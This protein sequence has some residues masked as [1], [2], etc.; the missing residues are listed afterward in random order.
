MKREVERNEKT[1]NGKKMPFFSFSFSP[2][3]TSFSPQGA[4]SDNSSSS[5]KNYKE[6]EYLPQSSKCKKT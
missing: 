6:R 1:K 5:S 2:T 3:A 4:R